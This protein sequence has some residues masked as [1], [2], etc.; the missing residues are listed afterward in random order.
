M[1]EWLSSRCVA[2]LWKSFWKLKK[3]VLSQYLWGAIVGTKSGA[4]HYFARV[5]SARLRFPNA[6]MTRFPSIIGAGA[7]LQDAGTHDTAWA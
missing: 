6:A 1:T 2:P 4:R 3:P 5:L 7:S